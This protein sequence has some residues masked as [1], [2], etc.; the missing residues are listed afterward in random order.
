MTQRLEEFEAERINNNPYLTGLKAELIEEKST[1]RAEADELGIKYP[2][3]ISD[4][5]L[6]EKID[7]L[8][9]KQ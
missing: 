2:A 6:Q 9:A 5:K 4:E 8:K 1:V 3:K 7:E